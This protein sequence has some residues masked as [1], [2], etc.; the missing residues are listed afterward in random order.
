M[1]ADDEK[2]LT[3]EFR[4]NFAAPAGTDIIAQ[5]KAIH[6]VRRTAIGDVEVSDHPGNLVAKGIV[7]YYIYTED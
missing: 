7:T 1:I 5:E 3:I 6:K 4:V 2:I